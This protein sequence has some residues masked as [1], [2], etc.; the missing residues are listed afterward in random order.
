LAQQMEIA[1]TRRRL[2]G[3]ADLPANLRDKR[4]NA[5]GNLRSVLESSA[6]TPFTFRTQSN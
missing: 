1:R 2:R 5:P 3:N 4:T 6:S